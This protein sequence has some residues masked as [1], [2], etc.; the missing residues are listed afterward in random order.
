MTSLN[1]LEAGRMEWEIK[2]D[3]NRLPW[4]WINWSSPLGSTC[5][6]ICFKFHDKRYSLLQRAGSV[7]T[8]NMLDVDESQSCWHLN[9]HHTA[10]RVFHTRLISNSPDQTLS[11]S[12][13]PLRRYH[14]SVHGTY[15][16]IRDLQYSFCGRS[17]MICVRLT[18]KT[19]TNASKNSL[20]MY[21]KN[22]GFQEEAKEL[23][24]KA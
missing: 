13:Q 7:K 24:K 23:Q 12:D 10:W 14:G 15:M 11:F 17:D 1:S 9:S 19:C 3:C 5:N 22:L 2:V 8:W 21:N 20:G 18:F 4:Q 6:D 16:Y